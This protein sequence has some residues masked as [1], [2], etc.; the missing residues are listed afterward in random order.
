MDPH[1]LGVLLGAPKKFSLH[2]VHSAQTVHLS[3]AEI[4]TFSKQT[5]MSIHLTHVTEEFDLVRSK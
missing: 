3:F 2:V 1:D 4:N 5:Q